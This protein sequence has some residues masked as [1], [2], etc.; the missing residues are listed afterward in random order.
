MKPLEIN[1]NQSS[2]STSSRKK[3]RYIT[4]S[5]KYK[6]WCMR[7]DVDK[8]IGILIKAHDTHEV[9][10]DIRE[11]WQYNNWDDYYVVSILV[12]KQKG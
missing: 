5:E 1:N 10:I 6:A 8:F 3:K 7:A 2:Q 9:S 4:L 12:G 11:K